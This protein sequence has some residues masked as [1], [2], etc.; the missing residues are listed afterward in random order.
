[1]TSNRNSRPASALPATPDP[2][3][4]ER[5]WWSDRPVPK[6]H[7]RL[8]TGEP[9]DTALFKAVVSGIKF[10]EKTLVPG[11]PYKAK[12]FVDDWD[13][14]GNGDRRRAGRCL[15]DIARR[16]DSP[17]DLIVRGKN[18]SHRYYVIPP[19]PSA[20]RDHGFSTKPDQQ[21]PL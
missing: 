18:Q 3:S 6:S 7:K 15:A 16:A 9:V 11:Y 2:N 17:I 1:M 4:S 14:L 13:E 19:A 12:Y 21:Q 10:A 5:L 8:R 20:P